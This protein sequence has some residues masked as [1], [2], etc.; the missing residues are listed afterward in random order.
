MSE[1]SSDVAAQQLCAALS[2]FAPVR[3]ELLDQA[4]L[5]EL[6]RL[7]LSHADFDT[8]AY[9]ASCHELR[10]T[11]VSRLLRCVDV[12]PVRLAFLSGAA[13]LEDVEFIL[14]SEQRAS[15][16]AAVGVFLV[17]LSERPVVFELFF[18]KALSSIDS[19]L[20]EALCPLAH[21]CSPG[22][23]V[24]LVAA[25]RGFELSEYASTRLVSAVVLLSSPGRSPFDGT[26]FACATNALATILSSDLAEP[27]VASIVF[28]LVPALGDVSD[29]TGAANMR[30]AGC[31]LSAL[32]RAPSRQAASQRSLSRLLLSRTDWSSA[33]VDE[34][35]A[36]GWV[37]LT[38]A[39]FSQLDMVA[40]RLKAAHM[41]DE[42]LP[43]FPEVLEVLASQAVGS[44]DQVLLSRL[45]RR[46]LDCQLSAARPAVVLTLVQHLLD[47]ELVARLLCSFPQ[48]AV[49]LS[50]SAPV[51]GVSALRR[52][53]I[54]RM[55]V[56]KSPYAPAAFAS[57]LFSQSGYSL[58]ALACH[59]RQ[60]LA[61]VVR[62]ALQTATPASRYL[63]SSLLVPSL[64]ECDAQDVLL[65]LDLSLTRV[66][67][68]GDSHYS[69]FLAS[70]FLAQSS[71]AMVRAT[72]AS[73]L[74]T[75]DGSPFELLRAAHLLCS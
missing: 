75:F 67:L 54:Q 44:G 49:S 35:V 48:A 17:R 72:C 37:N 9:L 10:G 28:E 58:V 63:L 47:D 25:C 73:L 62:V 52:S 38:Q 19:P 71:D 13:S 5:L 3:L 1:L 66:A 51:D 40:L 18:S 22:E 53:L 29:R 33:Q 32:I 68:V 34:L 36:S 16:L 11:P 59:D 74:P 30:L 14:L 61:D 42:E 43:C 26:V 55:H 46:V 7:A 2:L 21:M 8:L 41:V 6:T 39:P 64:V 50:S 27:L 24:S 15:V 31:A 45:A 69:S 4:T 12:L 23:L 56:S 57:L 60:L 70:F 20:L 65:S